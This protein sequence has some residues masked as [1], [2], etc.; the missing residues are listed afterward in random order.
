MK[1]FEYNWKKT[2]PGGLGTVGEVLMLLKDSETEA[3]ITLENS[4]SF[5]E[6]LAD[7]SKVVS[8]FERRG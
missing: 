3:A 8:C 7:A 5:R 2:V 1:K 6:L 4:I